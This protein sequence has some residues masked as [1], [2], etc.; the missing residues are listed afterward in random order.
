[1]STRLFAPSG[2]PLHESG[3][4]LFPPS[5]V[6]R[7]GMLAPCLNTGLVSVSDDVMGAFGDDALLILTAYAPM[8][9]TSAPMP[10]KTR[11]LRIS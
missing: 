4:E 10:T 11:L 5:Q 7:E 2:T 1:M 6:K 9:M 3:G 8:I